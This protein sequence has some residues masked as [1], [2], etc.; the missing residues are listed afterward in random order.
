MPSGCK[1][2]FFQSGTGHFHGVTSSV[3]RQGKQSSYPLCK[4]LPM[5]IQPTG[6]HFTRQN[7]LTSLEDCKIQVSREISLLCQREGEP[8]S[9]LLWG[10]DFIPCVKQGSRCTTHSTQS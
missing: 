10:R 3:K 2:L 4:P 5:L 1:V 6:T 9:W 8:E 7:N